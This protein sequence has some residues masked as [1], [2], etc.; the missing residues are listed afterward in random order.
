MAEKLSSAL[1]RQIQYVDIPPQT[2]RDALLG[3][4]LPQWQAEGLIED[5]A[6]YRQGEA[7]VIATGVQDAI[8]SPPRSFDQFAHDYAPALS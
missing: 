3:F 7:A 6:H 4:G 5:Y 1:N 2:M 8:G